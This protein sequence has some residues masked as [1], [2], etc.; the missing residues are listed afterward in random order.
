MD[1][2][3]GGIGKIGIKSRLPKIV[4]KIIELRAT[5][6]LKISSTFIGHPIKQK[7]SW[8]NNRRECSMIDF[9]LS[10]IGIRVPRQV[11]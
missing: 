1:D 7:K 11:I 9:I 6:E 8:N 10:N 3:H 4:A 2:F 5:N